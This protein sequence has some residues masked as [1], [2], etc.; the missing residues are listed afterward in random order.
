MRTV[1]S[2]PSISSWN[3]TRDAVARSD[4]ELLTHE[5]RRVAARLEI[6]EVVGA[7]EDLAAALEPVLGGDALQRRRRP[8]L[9]RAPSCR[10]TAR[11]AALRDTSTSR[12]R[13]RRRRTPTAPSTTS[14]SRCV[15]LLMRCSEYQRSAWYDIDP[16]AR[17]RA[18]ARPGGPTASRLPMAS[19]TIVTLTPLRA[20]SAQRVDELDRPI[21]AVLE[22][23]ALHVDG[24]RRA[25]DRVEHRRVERRAVGEDRDAVAVVQRRLAGRLDRVEKVL[26][27]DRGA[28]R[29]VVVDAGREQEDQHQPDEEEPRPP[30]ASH[31]ISAWRAR[32]PAGTSCSVSV[33]RAVVGVDAERR[34]D[35][36]AALEQAL[37]AAE[38]ALV[39]RRRRDGQV[40]AGRQPRDA[41]TAAR[42]RCRRS[43][44]G[45]SSASR[46]AARAE[47]TST[48]VL[49]TGS[50][51]AFCTTPLTSLPRVGDRDPHVAELLA[52]VDR[53]TAGR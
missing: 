9:R 52:L 28:L 14:S 33:G 12:R 49:A 38:I 26:V 43:A 7:G 30:T 6:G 29:Q 8:A 34:A 48:P 15:R 20:R 10:A 32:A 51:R 50:L 11:R 24:A 25:A 40:L 44:S 5:R 1:W 37:A 16:A 53:R 46:T 21:C 23:V 22:D 41:R 47:Q 17:P 2:A 39:D 19:T 36:C 31:A 3:V 4:G 18:A 27:V 45:G 35:R 13:R 42:D